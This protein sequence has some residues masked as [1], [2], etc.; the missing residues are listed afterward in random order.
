[1]ATGFPIR[2]RFRVKSVEPAHRFGGGVERV[3]AGLV[4]RRSIEREAREHAIAKELQHLT[5]ART[6][7]GGQ[8]FE[9]VV[10]HFNERPGVA[11]AIAVSPRISAYHRTARM[12]ST[13][14]RSTTPA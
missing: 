13:E 4:A 2:A 1:M 11:S 3:A 10:E 5:A 12:L 14:P 7:R 8:R 9:H 6:Q